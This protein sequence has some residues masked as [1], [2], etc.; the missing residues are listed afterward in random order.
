M[1]SEPDQPTGGLSVDAARGLDLD[2]NHPS[3]PLKN[4]V[5]L[6]TITVLEVKQFRSLPRCLDVGDQFGHHERL[7]HLPDQP[8]LAS[9]LF[10]CDRE[11]VRGHTGVGEVNFGSAG[12]PLQPFRVPGRNPSDHQQV[13]QE[14]NRAIGGAKIDFSILRSRLL[15]Q[16]LPGANGARGKYG[17]KRSGSSGAIADLSGISI[18]ELL[19]I[20]LVPTVASP[21]GAAYHRWESALGHGFE[22]VTAGV[23]RPNRRGLWRR[24]PSIDRVQ[25]RIVAE[26]CLGQSIHSDSDEPAGPR[27]S[28]SLMGRSDRAGDDE[29]PGRLRWVA[30]DRPFE[31]PQH[32]GRFLPLVDQH[33]P[34]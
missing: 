31:C 30:V 21:P 22:V 8:R 25:S 26:F 33:S 7:E 1:I 11:E 3:C 19:N 12:E 13:F 32:L 2:P 9:E 4:G 5:N 10:G 18:D 24:I 15:V 14:P 17:A 28:G 34:A 27:P 20:G 23:V 6:A 29:P 16:F